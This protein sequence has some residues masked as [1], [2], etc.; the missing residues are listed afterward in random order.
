MFPEGPENSSLHI[1]LFSV[2]PGQ[3]KWFFISLFFNFVV[4]IRIKY[5]P[6]YVYK[7]MYIT[8]M[9]CNMLV[10][11]CDSEGVEGRR[12]T[13][14]CVQDAFRDSNTCSKGESLSSATGSVCRAQSCSFTPQRLVLCNIC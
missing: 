14:L 6:I 11:G 2:R 4:H 9:T 8:R 7:V 10:R 1:L 3:A 5:I 13:L 12:V